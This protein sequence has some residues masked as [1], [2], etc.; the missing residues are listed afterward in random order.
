MVNAA[1]DPEGRRVFR[2]R[3]QLLAE[4]GRIG[5]TLSR[6]LGRGASPLAAEAVELVKRIGREERAAL[7]RAH[8]RIEGRRRYQRSSGTGNP[9]RDRR[10]TSYL[11]VDE[12]GVA[13]ATSSPGQTGWFALGA[14]AMSAEAVAHY[15]AASDRLKLEFFGR[16]DITLHEP[17][18]RRHQQDFRFEGDEQRLAEFEAGIRRLINAARF[19][20]FAVGIRKDAFR[21]EVVDAGSDFY[22]PET[23][24]SGAIHMLLEPYVDFLAHHPGDP[25]GRVIWE[26]QG[27]RE[28]AEH[29]R[30]VVETL[31]HGTQ[32]VSESAFRRFLEP[33]VVFEPKQGSHPTEL[34]DMLARDTFEW[35]RDD[36]AVDPPRWSL[37]DAKLYRR[38]HMAGL[39]VFPDSDI[40]RRAEEHHGARH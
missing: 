36:C 12:S 26:A 38:D 5:T 21:A 40:R 16:T 23:V 18:I 37:F 29:Q 14:V 7:H 15:V 34:S 25:R 35:I 27:P 31:L 8:G 24:Y 6:V 33:G 3:A 19:T 22:L 10:P 4:A 39:K 32:W 2:R 20:A 30:D 17:M 11:F 13:H 9:V 1:G 28:D